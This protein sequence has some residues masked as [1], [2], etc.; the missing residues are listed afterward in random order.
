MAERPSLFPFLPSFVIE[1]LLTH[2]WIKKRKP[3]TA[4]VAVLARR[5]RV[6]SVEIVHD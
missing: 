1:W 5:G 2:G 4:A 6:E 3:W